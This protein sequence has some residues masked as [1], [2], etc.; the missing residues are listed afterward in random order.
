MAQAATLTGTAFAFFMPE[1]VARPEF[2]L[3]MSTACLRFF[4]AGSHDTVARTKK[5]VS[6]AAAA[7]AAAAAASNG[8]ASYGTM[9]QG[10]VEP[11]ASASENL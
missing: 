2:N 10:E 7:G 5:T 8:V 11:A 6:S 9:V 4:G 3:Q 1:A